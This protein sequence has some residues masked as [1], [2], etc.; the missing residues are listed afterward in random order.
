VGEEVKAYFEVVFWH[1]RRRTEETHESLNHCR[2][3][4]VGIR[5]GCHL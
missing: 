4:P 1:Y 5:K 2:R 3:F